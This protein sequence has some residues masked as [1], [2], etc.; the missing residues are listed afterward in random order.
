MIM[1][2]QI[3]SRTSKQM[4]YVAII[5][6]IMMFAGLTSAYVISSNRE[7]WVSF[8]LPQA[9]YIS[10]LLIILSSISYFLAKKSIL[11]NNRSQTTIFLVI[12]LVLAVGFVFFQ[13]EGFNQLREVDLYFTGEGSVVS[14]SLLVVISFAHLLHVAAGLVVLLVVL[15]RHL[16]NKYSADNA[17]GLEVGGIFWHF[18][19]F[20]WIFLFLF[21]YFIT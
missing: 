11:K 1:D 5:S 14:S 12:T 8:D 18:V 20:L 9:L 2:A 17:L 3:R 6:M 13:F 15:F 19:D 21:F 10:T 4:M 7:D 16:N